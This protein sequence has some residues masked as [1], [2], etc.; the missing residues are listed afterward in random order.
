MLNTTAGAFG[1]DAA[2]AGMS[3]V[4]RVMM[5]AASAIIGFGQGFQPVCGFN[6][7]AKLYHRVKKAYWFCVKLS[8]VFLVILSVIMFIFAPSIIEFFR[9]GDPDVIA[10]GSFALRCQCITLSLSGFIVMSNMMLQTIG[11]A[12]PATAV[13]MS[14]QFIFFIPALFILSNLFGLLGVE[15]AQAV[16]DACSILLTIPLTIK[17]LREMKNN[18]AEPENNENLVESL[19]E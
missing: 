9:K 11:K 18:L 17:V 13:A 3:I 7:G 2:I 19:A 5:F 12:V 1:G 6:Y 10:V 16:A 14:R 4:T 8:T 15:I